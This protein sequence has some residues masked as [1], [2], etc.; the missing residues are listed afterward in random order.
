MILSS[1]TKII[2]QKMVFQFFL[3][4][5]GN[6]QIYEP[7]EPKSMISAAEIWRLSWLPWLWSTNLWMLRLSWLSGI[8]Q[9]SSSWSSLW[10]LSRHPDYPNYPHH[11]QACEYLPG[12]LIISIILIIFNTYQ[13]FSSSPH[14][15][16][17]GCPQFPSAEQYCLQMKW[18]VGI[19]GLFLNN[20]LCVKAT[21]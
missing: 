20:G 15:L 11:D 12:I 5:L 13:A 19:C 1:I 3:L 10:I 16:C 4:Y 7:S 18:L 9:T 8:S 21:C 17:K 14:C 6:A 2:L